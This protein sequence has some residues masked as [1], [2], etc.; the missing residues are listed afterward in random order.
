MAS[1]SAIAS[2]Q[3]WLII[4]SFLRSTISARAPA[5]RA[6][7][8]IDKL[9]EA[10]VS[11]TIREDATSEVISHD[12][13]TACIRLRTFEAI[14]ASQIA[15]NVLYFNGDNPEE[16]ELLLPLVLRRISLALFLSPIYSADMINLYYILQSYRIN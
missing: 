7:A 1:V 15:L 11:A 16:D 9:S 10:Q 6:R 5:G 8:E 12:S 4:R 2:I 3:L 13:P 14:A